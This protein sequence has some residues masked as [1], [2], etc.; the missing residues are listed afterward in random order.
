MF[1]NGELDEIRKVALQGWAL[2]DW[3]PMGSLTKTTTRVVIPSGNK[4]IDT[5]S[6]YYLPSTKYAVIYH[7][8][9]QQT[10]HS[11]TKS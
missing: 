4:R 11:N 8:G 1:S 9:W 2:V 5:Q 7:G 10:D 3:L 6:V